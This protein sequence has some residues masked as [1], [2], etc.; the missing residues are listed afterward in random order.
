[1]A[2]F[3]LSSLDLL[4]GL[5]LVQN[6]KSRIIDWIYSLQVEHPATDSTPCHCGF[7]GSTSA[8]VSNNTK[9]VGKLTFMFA[10]Y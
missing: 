3:A 8:K 6:D 5:E 1:M 7:R 9:K 2:L 4:G 10:C